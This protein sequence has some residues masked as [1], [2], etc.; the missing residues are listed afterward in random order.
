MGNPKKLLLSL[1]G[2]VISELVQLSLLWQ[3]C[4]SYQGRPFSLELR[5]VYILPI[6][7]GRLGLLQ[8]DLLPWPVPSTWSEEGGRWRMLWLECR[9]LWLD[10]LD[11]DRRRLAQLS[12]L[13]I[14][15]ALQ[16]GLHVHLAVVAV[17]RL[18]WC[19]QD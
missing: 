15:K 10:L 7:P 19:N 13:D 18:L 2:D 12:L 6:E 5:E 4:L 16:L 3:V 9:Q 11:E 1:L 17:R 14:N 8:L